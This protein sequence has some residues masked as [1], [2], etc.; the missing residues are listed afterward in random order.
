MLTFKRFQNLKDISRDSIKTIIHYTY[1]YKTIKKNCIL[2]HRGAAAECKR[3]DFYFDIDSIPSRCSEL[4]YFC[5]PANKRK[6]D[7]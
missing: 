7:V 5:R 2:S 3:D 6:L 4:F 1:K